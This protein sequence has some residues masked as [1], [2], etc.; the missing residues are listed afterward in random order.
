MNKIME[1]MIVWFAMRENIDKR[2]NFKKDRTM[3][4]TI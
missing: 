4:G 2:R 1:E 3:S